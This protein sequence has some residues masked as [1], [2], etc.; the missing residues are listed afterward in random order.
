MNNFGGNYEA[1]VNVVD[2]YKKKYKGI[3][4]LVIDSI[5]DGSK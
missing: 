4:A 5:K 2:E 1:Q 3:G